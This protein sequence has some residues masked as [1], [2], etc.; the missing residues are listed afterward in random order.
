MNNYTTKSI[1]P[2]NSEFT[3]ENP[4]LKVF[5]FQSLLKAY[6]QCRKCKRKTINA[7]KFEISFEKELLK[8][9][10]ELKN[11]IYRPGR[12]I[13]FVITDP[14]PREVFAAD[15]RDRIVHHLLVNYLEPTWEKKFIYHS[16][17]CHQNKGAHCAIKNLKRFSTQISGNFSKSAYY[18]QVDISTFFMS[19]KKDV[20]FNLIKRHIKHPDILWLTEQII[21]QDPTK[22]FYQKSDSKLF[23]LIPSHKS[24][25]KVPKNQGLPIGNLTSQFFANV[26]LNELDQFAKHQLKIKCY[27]RYVNDAIFL[28]QS[29]E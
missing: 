26:Y 16:Y 12:S 19:L 14:K 2:T 5:S 22:N 3:R 21:F 29:P 7:T 6:Y 17:S 1:Y 18:L 9:E 28:H 20:L 13:C 8:L 15:F 23:Q 4:H 10:W 25:F 11:H 27:V 24:L